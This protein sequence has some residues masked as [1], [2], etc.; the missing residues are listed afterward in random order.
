VLGEYDVEDTVRLINRDAGPNSNTADAEEYR[1]D[2]SSKGN[3]A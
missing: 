2:K 3:Y 1:Y